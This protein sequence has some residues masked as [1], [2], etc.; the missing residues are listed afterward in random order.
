M[1]DKDSNTSTESL[2]K[3]ILQYRKNLNYS[4][5]SINSQASQ[6][7][8]QMDFLSHGDKDK[9]PSSPISSQTSISGY[10]NKSFETTVIR[11]KGY[12]DES[13]SN[14]CMQNNSKD[15]LS[16][17]DNFNISNDQATINVTEDSEEKDKTAIEIKPISKSI[18]SNSVNSNSV[19]NNSVNSN[20]VVSNSIVSNSG[21]SNSG[22]SNSGNSNRGNSNSGNSN[23]RNGN[24]RNNNSGN[25]NSG[26]YNSGD[27]NNVNCNN[28]ADSYECNCEFVREELEKIKYELNKFKDLIDE[29]DKKIIRLENV[30]FLYF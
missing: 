8:D 24:R 25:Y 9:S 3:S 20:S 7:N 14:Y 27:S 26:N 29:K 12:Q 19:N 10:F 4:K 16:H 17:L 23:S 18:N 13:K 2:W 28:N 21:N 30:K 1:S 5:Q 6:I 11:K 15:F 22:N